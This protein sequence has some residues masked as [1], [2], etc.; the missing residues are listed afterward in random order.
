MAPH[1]APCSMGPVMSS[2]T[3]IVP[4]YG[5][6]RRPVHVPI[7]MVLRWL[8]APVAGGVVGVVLGYWCRR[9]A[10]TGGVN[11]TL[12]D[13]GAPWVVAA[14]T[15]GA[16]TMLAADRRWPAQLGAAV[17]GALAGATSLVVATLVYYGPAQTGRLDL[18]DARGVTLVW[19]IVGVGVGVVI[20]AAGALW[21]AAPNGLQ[22]TACLVVVGT[23]VTSEAYYLL[24]TGG[25]VDGRAVLI[26]V[27]AAGIGLP[28]LRGLRWGALLGLV[29]VAI[30]A[31][32]GSLL[33]EI[34]WRGTTDGIAFLHSR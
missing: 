20:G 2:P 19:S 25:V 5:D 11:G 1:R 23:A 7:P 22:A 24:D 32:P 3:T 13:L 4:A 34:V 6:Q 30:A 17:A 8:A 27:A 31:V 10:G 28:L 33:A 29:L 15:A 18:P 16:V 14:F 21:R 9:F 12:A 26:A